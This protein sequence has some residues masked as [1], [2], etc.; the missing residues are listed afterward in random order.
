MSHPRESNAAIKKKLENICSL[1]NAIETKEDEL[2]KEKKAAAF[3]IK[4][5]IK[6]SERETENSIQ[7]FLNK[8]P[9]VQKA[10]VTSLPLDADEIFEPVADTVQTAPALIEEKAVPKDTPKTSL[11]IVEYK[12]RPTD[13]KIE[14]DKILKKISDTKIVL[15]FHLFNSESIVH[16]LFSFIRNNDLACIHHMLQNGISPNKL[17]HD[18]VTLYAKDALQYAIEQQNPEPIY[19]ILA[20]GAKVDNS[21]VSSALENLNRHLHPEH[22]DFIM[23]ELTKR[24]KFSTPAHQAAFEGNAAFFRKVDFERLIDRDYRGAT[25]LHHIAATGNIDCLR[26]LAENECINIAKLEELLRD[27]FTNGKI[28]PLYYAVRAN[29]IAFVKELVEKFHAD[30]NEKI[31]DDRLPV[32][33]AAQSEE[34]LRLLVN[35]Y[36]VDVNYQNFRGTVLHELCRTKTIM[37]FTME[38]IRLLV[39]KFGLNI[40]ARNKDGETALMVA[41]KADCMPKVKLLLECQASASLLDA[42]DQG[43]VAMAKSME[44]AQFLIENNASPHVRDKD[45]KTLLHK[46]SSADSAEFF[47]NAGVDVNTPD[48]QGN[49]PLHY[50]YHLSRSLVAC[51]IKNGANLT[52][53]NNLHLTPMLMAIFYE[54]F[55]KV[56]YLQQLGAKIGSRE[57]DYTLKIFDKYFNKEGVDAEQKKRFS[58][59]VAYIYCQTYLLDTD[60]IAFH[61]KPVLSEPYNT[62]LNTMEGFGESKLEETI[63]ALKLSDEKFFLHQ[64]GKIHLYYAKHAE[65][66]PRKCELMR[67]AEKC[68]EAAGISDNF[69][70]YSELLN[71]ASQLEEMVY[72]DDVD[73][74]KP[75]PEGFPARDQV[76]LLK[77]INQIKPL[78][79]ELF[80]KI[81]LDKKLELSPIEHVKFA[82]LILRLGPDLGLTFDE[83]LKIA[84]DHIELVQKSNDAE[85]NG[86]VNDSLYF[87]SK[88]LNLKEQKEESKEHKGEMKPLFM[89]RR[90]IGTDHKHS[91]DLFAAVK[92]KDPAQIVKIKEYLEAGTDPNS[93]DA[94]RNTPLHYVTYAEA[95]ECLLEFGAN[96]N[97]I[98]AKSLTP[99]H[100]AQ[101]AGVTEVLLKH[102][103]DCEAKTDL[104]AGWRRYLPIHYAIHEGNVPKVQ[105]LTQVNALNVDLL[106]YALEHLDSL[107]VYGQ[108]RTNFNA[109]Y[110][111]LLTDLFTMNTQLTGLVKP[112]T[113][114]TLWQRL[115]RFNTEQIRHHLPGQ[116]SEAT[117]NN[118]VEP[119][120]SLILGMF[121]IARNKFKT[122]KAVFNEA[123]KHAEPHDLH[124]KTPIKVYMALAKDLGLGLP[125]QEAKTIN[126]SDLKKMKNHIRRA[127]PFFVIGKD[128]LGLLELAKKV[129]KLIY[130][131]VSQHPL[132]KTLRFVVNSI[133]KEAKLSEQERREL[134]ALRSKANK[135][136][137]WVVFEEIRDRAKEAT[138]GKPFEER[139]ATM[140]LS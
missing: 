137:G 76:I 37:P 129:D 59:L 78:Q 117:K 132:R 57:L 128:Y 33:I 45:G 139:K 7:R 36:R 18:G 41:V 58:A 84:Q 12:D 115:A 53:E 109:T 55:D 29:H 123:G 67:G 10:I 107:S 135:R 140:S 96:P 22:F 19:L 61:R 38:L 46:A 122:A 112:S 136:W 2:N 103:A 131:P 62:F 13:L 138:K 3:E 11:T 111:T 28:N 47:I 56:I 95:A 83:S 97:V 110:V 54:S 134:D 69:N 120:K 6:H 113:Q 31:L 16:L 89:Q 77:K 27:P 48:S 42:K 82:K 90:V 20:M 119:Y 94:E 9:L 125:P 25:A 40:D 98:N 66:Y 72:V 130:A 65:D 106:F 92:S 73:H 64:L 52:A 60:V 86:I 17:V 23:A 74:G 49:T 1:I 50:S 43:M 24:T 124:F 105:M 116:F 70:Y 80:A 133:P 81:P 114:L 14:F 85:A 34:M 91:E 88:I 4:G 100:T 118:I 87:V 32:I 121:L 99:L 104:R 44:M 71:M 127:V 51:L 8:Y 26:A 68:F 5:F 126:Q 39:T 30:V 93:L 79:L 75:A 108:K 101:T 102:A 21:H 35:E 15:G 63:A